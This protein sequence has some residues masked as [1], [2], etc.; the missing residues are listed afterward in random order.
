MLD[1]GSSELLMIVIVAVVVIGP[2]DL[3]RAL[4]KLGQIMGKARAMSRHFRTGLDAMVREAEL[5]EMEKKW[6]ADNER[7][8]KQYPAAGS[9]EQEPLMEALPAPAVLA[10]AEP[11]AA[12]TA[13]EPVQ[14]IQDGQKATH[15]V[16]EAA[17]QPMLPLDGDEQLES[18]QRSSV[19]G[20]LA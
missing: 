4:Y 6:A 2:K 17:A 3:P 5:E 19:V 20:K 13:V 1:I 7:I 14:E 16:S 10:R 18:G 15:V 11:E 9:E 12:S 8:M